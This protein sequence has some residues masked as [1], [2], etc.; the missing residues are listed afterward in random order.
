MDILQSEIVIVVVVVVAIV[1]V[2]KFLIGGHSVL[3]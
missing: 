2:S 3:I 1:V